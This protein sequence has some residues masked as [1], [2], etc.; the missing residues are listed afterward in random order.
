MLAFDGNFA[1]PAGAHNLR[2]ADRVVRIG[3]VRC[4]AIAALA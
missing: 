4:I 3:L 1:I 2:Q